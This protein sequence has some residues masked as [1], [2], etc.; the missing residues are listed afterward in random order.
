MHSHLMAPTAVILRGIFDEDYGLSSIAVFVAPDCV[1][2]SFKAAQKPA[3]GVENGTE[4]GVSGGDITR[5][6][7]GIVGTLENHLSEV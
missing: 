5:H 2:E 6:N 1:G 3:L 4:R 7:Q